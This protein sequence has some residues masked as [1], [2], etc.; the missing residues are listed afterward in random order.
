ME[1]YLKIFIWVFIYAV[2][3]T[4]LEV[5][6]MI[7]GNCLLRFNATDD[8]RVFY[9]YLSN[10]NQYLNTDINVFIAYIVPVS[11]LT[12][13]KKFLCEDCLFR[14]IITYGLPNK[15]DNFA[16]VGCW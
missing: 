8:S 4:I 14:Y 15:F 11:K 7:S 13:M 5:I 6:I 10:C 3:T 9:D 2:R 16:C 12:D 1:V